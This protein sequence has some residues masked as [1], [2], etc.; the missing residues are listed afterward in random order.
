M[1][2]NREPAGLFR[3]VPPCNRSPKVHEESVSS[4]VNAGDASTSGSGSEHKQWET[5]MYRDVFYQGDCDDGMLA[6]ADALGWGE[7]LQE[8]TTELQAV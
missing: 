8:V 5:S 1:L 3:D 4:N 2:V 7:R 6:L